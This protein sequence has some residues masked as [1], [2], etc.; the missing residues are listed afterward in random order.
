MRRGHAF[1]GVLCLRGTL[2]EVRVCGAARK[3]QVLRFAQDD[4]SLKVFGLSI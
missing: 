3:K 2:F 4:K 1:E